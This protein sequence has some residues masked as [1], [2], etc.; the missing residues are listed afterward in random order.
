[1][2]WRSGNMTGLA[3]LKTIL[4]HGWPMRC[5]IVK[6][7]YRSWR[8]RCAGSQKAARVFV[9]R[10]SHDE[11]FPRVGAKSWKW[12]HGDSKTP[13]ASFCGQSLYACSWW[14]LI[15]RHTAYLPVTIVL[16][17]PWF[18]I[19][20]NITEPDPLWLSSTRGNCP[21]NSTRFCRSLPVSLWEI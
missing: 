15:S 13:W 8:T 4:S 5:G 10:S 1:M 21:V 16:Q 14:N 20:Q 18:I 2:N 7:H 9:N 12:H 17:K 19:S 3:A 6:I 11:P